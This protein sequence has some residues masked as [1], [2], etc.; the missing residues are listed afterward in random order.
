MISIIR[1]LIF[2]ALLCLATYMN[3]QDMKLE[4]VMR[5]TPVFVITM[6]HHHVLWFG[7]DAGLFNYNSKTFKEYRFDP[8]DTTSLID[9]SI[10]SLLFD[11]RNHLWVGTRN[12]LNRYRPI[13]DSFDRYNPDPS[14][15][16][17]IHGGFVSSLAE[18]NDGFIW[19]GTESAGLHRLN[20]ISGAIVH[21]KAGD[22]YNSVI[23]NYIEKIKTDNNGGLWVASRNGLNYR[24]RSTNQWQHYL[25]SASRNISPDNDLIDLEIDHQGNIWMS[26]RNN[27]LYILKTNDQIVSYQLQ[28][29]ISA[30]SSDL[31]GN[32]FFGTNDG[33]IIKV[34][35][36]SLSWDDAKTIYHDYSKIGTIRSI[37]HDKWDNIWIGSEN[38][39]FVHYKTARHFV[40]IST[41][42][43]DLM[44]S[45]VMAMMIDGQDRLWLSSGE[46]MVIKER[47]HSGL[48]RSV[49]RQS[50]PNVPNVYTFFQDSHGLIWMGTHE[51]GLYRYDPKNHSLVRYL[52]NPD[53][54]Y[55]LGHNSIWAITEDE[56]Q[57]L[58]LGS[59]GGG[60]IYYNRNTRSFKTFHADATQTNTLNHPKILSLLYDRDSI[61][62]I[63]TDGGGLNSYDPW[64]NTFSRHPIMVNGKH[65]ELDRSILSLH[66]DIKG[67]IWIGTDGGGLAMFD[68]NNH[69]YHVYNETHGLSNLS[70]KA[71]QEDLSHN[72]WVSTNG[73]G[74]FLFKSSNERFIQFT[75]LD[76]ISTNRFHNSCALAEREGNLYFGGFNGFTTFH[77]D[78]IETTEY[79]PGIL[80][81]SI[82]IN[83]EEMTYGP[84]GLLRSAMESGELRL[85]PGYQLITIEF[86]A[87]EY[88]LS[89]KNSYR[90]RLKEL[91]DMWTDIG[92]NRSVSFMNLPPGKYRLEIQTTN[93]DGLWSDD[94]MS[95]QLVVLPPFYKTRYF[96]ALT[97]IIL[98]TTLYGLYRYNI[99]GMKKRQLLLEE[100]VTLRTEKIKRQS[101]ALEQQNKALIKQKQELTNRNRKIIKSRER[102]RLMTKK[103]HEADQMKLRFFTNISHE[104]R[105]PLTL[106]IGPL[107]HLIERFMHSRDNTLDHLLTMR[108]NAGRIL[109]LFDQ[110][111]TIRKAESGSLKLR[112][113]LGNI[114]HFINNLTDSFREFAKQKN[115]HIRF[116]S[117]PEKIFLH[118]DEEKIEKIFT[119]LLSNA[120]KFTNTGGEVVISLI[121]IEND[122]PDN[123]RQVY[124][125][126]TVKITVSD[127]G[128][129]IP[130]HEQ[131]NI[132]NRFYQVSQKNSKTSS[133]GVGIGLSLVKS[134]VGIH[135]GDIRVES[136]PGEG[137]AF[138]VRIPRGTSHLRNSQI[139]ES[140]PQRG[141]AYQLNP[142]Q[143]DQ[144]LLEA[145]LPAGISK[146]NLHNPCNKKKS[147]TVLVVED[148]YDLRVFL[149]K[150]LQDHYN[151][152]EAENGA[153]GLDTIKKE[154][155]DLVISDVIMPG[156]DGFE[157]LK[158]LK[159]DV[160]IS[161]IPVIMLTAKADL[162]D[163]IAGL[164]LFADAYIAKPFHLEHLLTVTNNL[165]E[166]RKLVQNRYRDVFF[167]EPEEIEVLSADEKF[168]KKAK[169]IIEQNISNP[170]FDVNQLSREVGVSRAGVYRKMKALT[171]MSVSIL[172]RSIRMKRAAQILAQNK[173]NVS[174]V[175]YM[176]GFNDVQYFRKC[177]LKTYKVPPSQYAD[178]ESDKSTDKSH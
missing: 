28:Y 78:R 115:I 114:S 145:S 166:N 172:I 98:L 117:H 33:R 8:R 175:A 140:T 131:S 157:L 127:N 149:S 72:L 109:K 66:E 113:S 75:T 177:F 26:S 60:L 151:V 25:A 138:I 152:L 134:L 173:I 92:K 135:Y 105:T 96:F 116:T 24:D 16:K 146:D 126:G 124:P 27:I 30:I 69:A 106:I 150:W 82:R 36:Y 67:H 81:T 110:I 142:V 83:N 128:I 112:T 85:K 20:P 47:D 95:L 55:S 137:S 5:D 122:N 57:N 91:N 168:L 74:I 38:G 163:K 94:I 119:N 162:S 37:Y 144:I 108:Q 48:F 87:V 68:K 43:A 80:M 44:L 120:L 123:D 73:G 158:E 71:I 19:V 176:V 156:M 76:G 12:G 45:S 160:E 167:M 42:T 99:R 65:S 90:Y 18:D 2:L 70:V 102:I 53:D 14:S 164:K 86:A 41:N 32:I 7:T 50:I 161:H 88:S 46:D 148:N 93:S 31:H 155:P 21:F 52:H 118:F 51:K 130:K 103:V 170:D 174:E 89:D 59:W 11:S 129:G 100:K 133:D 29:E 13:D 165:L 132:F 6:D 40:S 125:E 77:P 49:S 15:E 54:P 104:L 22:N 39:L 62:W 35:G 84:E 56:E 147:H 64:K 136:N 171:N 97:A 121:E 139:S 153:A 169:A 141:S 10:R 4:Q 101:M 79:F 178:K 111:I 107:E 61:L 63:G 3:G 17:R 34:R 154:F 159:S 58:W 1:K 143:S 9:N 23:S